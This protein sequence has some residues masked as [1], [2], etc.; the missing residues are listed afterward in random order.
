[1]FFHNNAVNV[2][3]RGIWKEE[4]TRRAFFEEFAKSNGFDPL[5]LDNWLTKQKLVRQRKV[6][7][8]RRNEI[9]NNN[10]K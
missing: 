10:I 7:I 3:N 1:M 6:R 5:I 2:V 8:W 9:I 4:S